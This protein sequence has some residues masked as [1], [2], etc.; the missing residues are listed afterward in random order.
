MTTED[1]LAK[2]VEKLQA[3]GIESPQ[4]EARM[5]LAAAARLTREQ[6][7]AYNID[8]DSESRTT[9]DAML[10]RRFNGEPVAYVVGSKEFCGRP[11]Y[12][13]AHVLIPRPETELLVDAAIRAARRGWTCVD[14]GTG[15]GCIGI[16]VAL[17]MPESRW[18]CADASIAALQVARKNAES[19][20]ARVTLLQADLLSVFQN[21]SIDMVVSNPPYVAVGD[22][23]LTQQVATWEPG[24]A[25]LA[26]VDGLD[27]ITS[28]VAQAQHALK[29]SGV[30]MFEFGIGQEQ[31]VGDLLTGWACEIY[32]DLAGIPRYAVASR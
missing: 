2:A 31:G 7:V 21:G 28:L 4:R 3:A 15:S 9:A 8:L 30:L 13:S 12:V 32:D 25:L 23:R 24:T 1:W 5:L 16:S 29:P 18:I 11:F 22:E 6:L 14:V 17:E 26:G 27:I 19:L 20:R 10:Q